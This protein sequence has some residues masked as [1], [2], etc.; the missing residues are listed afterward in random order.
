M[1]RLANRALLLVLAA[2]LPV[3]GACAGKG[4]EAPPPDLAEFATRY[5][6]AWCSQDPARVAAFYAEDGVLAINGGEPAAGRAA[7]AA[8]AEGFMTAFP[9]MVVEMDSLVRAGDRVTY[10]WTLTGTNTGPG[11]TGQPVRIH[12]F[13]AWRFGPDGLI[14]DSRGQFDAAD[15]ERQLGGDAPPPDWEYDAAM[16][17]PADRSLRRPEDGVALP[18]GRLMVADQEYG[19][20]LVESDGR[21]APFGKMPAAGYEHEPP[22]H[23]GGANGVSMEPDGAHLLVADVF[24][25]GIYRVEIATRATERVYRHRYGVNAAVRD[26]RGAIW[27]TQSARN[28]PEEGEPRMWAAVDF[29]RPEGALLRLG[30]E[31]GRFADRAEVL[32]DSLYFANGVAIDETN[33]H[34]YV[35]ETVGG[36]V[37][38]YDVDL[39]AGRISSPAVVLEG[40]GA[41]NLELDEH[42]R[43]WVAL[44]LTNELR[45]IYT[46]TGASYAAFRAVT[47]E[48]IALMAEFARRA[49]TGESRLELFGPEAWEPLP[50][51]LTGVILD[52]EGP[53]YLTDLGDAL[54]R[55][56]R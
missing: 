24:G 25:G 20:R 38:R 27:F 52:D 43:L 41:D 16:V 34:L 3:F 54:V 29:P 36:R 5:T 56:P 11:G 6:E 17:F 28:T 44:P 48:Q 31:D 19:L 22:A 51:A 10:H 21:S 42:G 1:T 9:D 4:P 2:T 8:D 33:G 14:A 39:D 49:E 30:F 47:P 45:A 46:A 12:G 18:D 55:L 26:S 53:A 40:Q 13:E 35:A 37:W 32:V 23:P 7:I 50:G 15:Y